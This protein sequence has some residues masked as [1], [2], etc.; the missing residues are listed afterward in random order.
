MG[1]YIDPIAKTQIIERLRCGQVLVAA[2]QNMWLKPC[3]RIGSWPMH[4]MP[5]SGKVQQ[6]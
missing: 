4:L 3:H 2:E 6:F 5:M 1:F